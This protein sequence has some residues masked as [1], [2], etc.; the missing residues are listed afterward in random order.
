MRDEYGRIT[1]NF[2]AWEKLGYHLED[3]H[4]QTYTLTD[5]NDFYDFTRIIAEYAPYCTENG[6]PEYTKEHFIYPNSELEPFTPAELEQI[7]KDID[8]FKKEM[9]NYEN[10]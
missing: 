6:L 7:K 10:N 9:K 4:S 1:P 3:I 8:N 2:E 5:S